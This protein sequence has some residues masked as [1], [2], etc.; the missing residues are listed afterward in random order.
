MQAIAKI[1]PGQLW[2]REGERVCGLDAGLYLV[3]RYNERGAVQ[4]LTES[5]RL[6]WLYKA[7]LRRFFSR[8]R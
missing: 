5:G 1:K 3:M 8:F 7:N 6:V 2:K 4:V